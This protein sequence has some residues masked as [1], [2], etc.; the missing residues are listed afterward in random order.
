MTT[1]NIQRFKTSDGIILVAKRFS[2][3]FAGSGWYGGVSEE[4]YERNGFSCGARYYFG[5]D[6]ALLGEA[7]E[8]AAS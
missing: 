1:N 4:M 2:D 3:N 8:D 7:I 6:I 5:N